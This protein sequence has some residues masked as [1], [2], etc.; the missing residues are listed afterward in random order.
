M[1]NTLLFRVSF[2]ALTVSGCYAASSLRVPVR[3]QTSPVGC[4]ELADQVFFEAGYAKV[5]GSSG[6]MVYTPRG[7]PASLTVPSSTPF[8]WGIGVWKPERASWS[9]TA[10]ACEY[11]LQAI[12]TDPTCAF[13]CLNPPLVF[14][15]DVARVP[16]GQPSCAIQC[17]MTPQPGAQFDE[18]TRDMAGRLRAAGSPAVSTTEAAR[19]SLE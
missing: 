18:A 9:D 11:E 17:P 12:S 3:S 19:A 16:I 15:A 1:K 2:V 4:V 14:A 10:G 7:A 6:A 8:N 13:Q 5:S